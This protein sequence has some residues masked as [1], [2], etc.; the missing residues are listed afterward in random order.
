LEKRIFLALSPWQS[1]TA[2]AVCISFGVRNQNDSVVIDT[3]AK[4]RGI[5]KQSDNK[6]KKTFISE[7]HR[8]YPEVNSKEL[9]KGAAI[10]PSAAPLMLPN[11]L[12][13]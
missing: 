12:S 5:G 2:E 13:Y 1:I 10:R 7:K 8:V 11:T 4:G 9:V 6:T 3:I